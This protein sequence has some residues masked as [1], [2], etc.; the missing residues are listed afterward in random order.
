LRKFGKLAPSAAP[1]LDLEVFQNPTGSDMRALAE[2][3]SDR[4]MP[5][6]A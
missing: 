3:A 6:E 5:G 2:A 1:W 4:P